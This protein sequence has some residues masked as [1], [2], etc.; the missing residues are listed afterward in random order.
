MKRYS[1]RYVPGVGPMNAELL[2]VGEAPGRD[3]DRYLE[4]FVGKS[5]YLFQELLATVGLQKR[6]VRIENVF[7]YRP[8]ANKIEL[9]QKELLEEWFL[10]LHVFI[11]TMPNLKVIVPMGNY[12]LYALTEKGLVKWVKRVKGDKR[13]GITSLRGTVFPY[14][15]RNGRHLK[16][17]PTLHP[18]FVGREKSATG[19][20]LFDLKK[21]LRHCQFSG[22][23]YPERTLLVGPSFTE[24]E[25][26]AHRFYQHGEA[27]AYDIENPSPPSS[28]TK[29]ITC[30]SFADQANFS[31]SIPTTKAYWGDYRKRVVEIIG[32][33]MRMNNPKITQN[34]I[35]DH[36]C[37]MWEWG[38][39]PTAWIWD[40]LAMSHCYNPA[41]YSHALHF[42]AS[43]RT[44]EPYWKDE[45]KQSDEAYQW[46]GHL[47]QFWRYNAKD[48]AVTWELYEIWSN[49]LHESKQMQFYLERYASLFYPLLDMSLHGIRVDDGIRRRRSADAMATCIELQDEISTLAGRQMYA[50]VSLSSTAMKDYLYEQ[51][52]LPKQLVKNKQTNEK[53]E[54]V[55]EVAIRKLML[56][57]PQQLGQTGP[58]ILK[59][60]RVSTL[61]NFYKAE[62]LDDDERMRSEYWMNTEEGRL[63][64]KKNPMNTGANAQNVDRAARD[65]YLADEGCIAISV[66]YSQ[67][68]ARIVDV[69]LYRSTR[70][71]F[72]L[73]RALSK[74]WER[75]THTE[76]A[77][78]VFPN[79]DFS[80]LTPETFYDVRFLG[81]KTRHALPRGLGPET[82]Q[83]ELL[84]DGYVRD[85]TECKQYIMNLMHA[86][87]EHLDYFRSV[88]REMCETRE[89]VNSF[90]RRLKFQWDRL[91]G[92]EASQAFRRGY[93]FRPQ[94]DCR[95]LLSHHGLIPFYH[96][97]MARHPDVRT[98]AD[99]HDE[100]L[101]SA[102]KAKAYE[103]TM[104]LVNRMEQP[105]NLYG[106]EFMCPTS[107]TVGSNW[108]G[109][110]EWKQT[111]S[112][113]EFMEVI[114]ALSC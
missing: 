1:E 52:R 64:S 21:A 110:K 74:P 3:E 78:I 40:T 44:D 14:Q 81:K 112:K 98:N 33:I 91:T 76:T 10:K 95:D 35:Y 30:M 32:E 65:M 48:S 83:E 87:P 111:P 73:E 96:Y 55:N 39:W 107:I 99:V 47:E 51:L 15:D 41:E 104:W 94:S 86:E 49:V 19:A 17:I 23:A 29:P 113:E 75:D 25:E 22:L 88:E 80:A 100:I 71:S 2:F 63:K 46:S 101:F 7:P 31:I 90:G 62:R 11:T 24:V 9:I 28:K 114:N 102:P 59:H 45:S 92:S 106:V 5:G 27:I 58:L 37:L 54:T 105:H 38:F 61:G 43:T 53:T 72:Y 50:K 36:Y 68:E 108:K 82:M 20:V 109:A 67:I 66:D 56:K 6:D 60:R 89:L 69:L 79:M 4:P 93:S 85:V 16:V 12:A 42:Q 77:Q 103:V 57:F 70:K 18:A 97:R 84:K 8:L 26:V 13:P 34:G